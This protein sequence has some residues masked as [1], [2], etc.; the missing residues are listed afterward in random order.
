MS[1]I[2]Q[3]R[4]NFPERPRLAA[5]RRRFARQIRF[6]QNRL[7]PQGYL[8]LHLTLGMLVIIFGSWLFAEIAEDVLRHRPLVI[9]DYR[10]ARWLHERATPA[11]TEV[12][13]AIT[14]LG[15]TAFL[16]AASTLCALVLLWQKAWRWLLVFA[17]TM[18]GGGLLVLLLKHVF[19]RHRPIFENPIVTLSGFGFPSGHALGATLFFG[20]LTVLVASKIVKCWHGRVLCVVIAF[21][22][23]LL[24]GVSRVYL[25]A[26][27]LSDVIGAIVA[28]IVWLAFCWTG[29][30]TLRR[31]PR[32]L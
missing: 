15:S 12:A 31:R 14:F 13:K 9:L 7:S 23:I 25:G 18:A 29:V 3:H 2:E 17:V 20:I 16:S 24:V 4:Q 19:Q 5:F 10:V 1:D 28:A 32:R 27:Y 6:L 22:L 21:L 30:E 8:G 26:H 11:I